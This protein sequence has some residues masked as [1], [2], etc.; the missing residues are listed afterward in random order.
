MQFYSLRYNLLIKLC[1]IIYMCMQ[2][3]LNS[4]QRTLMMNN[5]INERQS[6]G[7]QMIKDK[8]LKKM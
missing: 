4:S 2:K 6:K 1:K 5:V 3:E 8:D 7:R